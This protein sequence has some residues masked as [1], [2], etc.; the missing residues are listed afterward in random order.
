MDRKEKTYYQYC[1]CPECGCKAIITWCPPAYNIQCT[2]CN[3]AIATSIFHPIDLD[4]ALYTIHL[5]DSK[6]ITKDKLK[7]LSKITGKN[8]IECNNLLSCGGNVLSG[9]A[10]DINDA[11]D[12]MISMKM[13]LTISPE[14]KYYNDPISNEKEWKIK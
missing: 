7:L 11:I 13:E 12:E 9:K 3:Y 14:W 4:E 1:K 10:S 2:K 6:I 5:K 8:Y